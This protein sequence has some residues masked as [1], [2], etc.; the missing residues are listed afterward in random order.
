[1]RIENLMNIVKYLDELLKF[2]LG[3]FGVRL[4]KIRR[5]QNL[6]YDLDKYKRSYAN[7]K[8]IECLSESNINNFLQNIAQSKSQISQDLFVLSQLNFKKNG[9]FVEFGATNGIDL[10][11]TYLLEKE[12]GWTGILAEPAHSW[13]KSL[14]ENRTAIIDERCV[15]SKSNLFLEF[16]ETDF[17][18]LSTLNQYSDLDSHKDA[19][20]HGKV[21]QV[22]TVSLLDLLIENNAPKEIDYLSI[23]TEG[24]EFEILNNFDF[25]KYKIKLI[26]CEHNYTPMRKHIFDLLSQH[27][28]KRVFTEISEFD[29]WYVK[30]D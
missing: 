17:G 6:K 14:K 8:L 24:S 27:G 23:D 4:L 26:T 19:R 29:D 10:S 2:S 9:F 3:V 7:L 5:Y 25:S 21:Y 28:Y 30:L 11:N 20:K 13:K 15:W 1:M 12:F 16:N 22:K 18:E